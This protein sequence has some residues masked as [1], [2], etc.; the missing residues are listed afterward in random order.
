MKRSKNGLVCV[1]HAY[2]SMQVCIS[3]C[4]QLSVCDPHWETKWKTNQ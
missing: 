1:C 2:H 4:L 3:M